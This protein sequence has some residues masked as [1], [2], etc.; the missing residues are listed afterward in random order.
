MVDKEKMESIVKNIIS[1]ALKY[2]PENGNVQVFVSE[3]DS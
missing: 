3:T 2:T 1:N